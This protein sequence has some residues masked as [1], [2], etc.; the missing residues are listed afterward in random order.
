MGRFR[1]TLGALI[2]VDLATGRP[3]FVAPTGFPVKD[4][5][6]VRGYGERTAPL[7]LAYLWLWSNLERARSGCRRST[8]G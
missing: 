6:V 7:G 1:R 4:V 3:L 8:R 5:S 2:V